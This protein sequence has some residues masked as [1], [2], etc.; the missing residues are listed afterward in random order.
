MG[1]VA[2]AAAREMGPAG[3]RATRLV[4]TL[5]ATVF[6][7]WLGA[8]AI[9]PMLPVFVRRLGGSDVAAGVVMASF[10]A[11]GVLLQYPTGRLADRIGRR[12]VLIG[13]LLLFGAASLGFLAPITPADA[14]LLRALQ[15]AGA[16]AAG[17]AS[18]AMISGSVALERRGRAFAAVYGGEIAGLAIGPL[19]G[20]VIGTRSMWIVFMGSAVLS[21]A[22]SVAALRVTDPRHAVHGGAGEPR[23]RE[24]LVLTRA[25]VGALLAGSSLGLTTGVYEICWT[26]LLVSK[27]AS[28]AEIGISWTLFA[29]PFVLVAK[30]SGWLAD[31]VDRRLLVV[32]GIGSSALLCSSYAFIPSVPVLV[33][34]G[35]VEA[36]SFAAALPSMQSLLTE[37]ADPAHV[38]RL[39]GLFATAQTACTAVAAAAA[40]AAFAT[41]A[42]LPFV[43]VAAL[44]LGILVVTWMVW[45]PVRGHV[46]A[47]RDLR[48][49]APA[50]G[51]DGAL[52]GLVVQRVPAW[53]EAVQRPVIGTEQSA[54]AARSSQPTTSAAL[55]SE[56]TS[57][58]SPRRG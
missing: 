15:G 20:S 30:P 45:R 3:D 35:A 37:G 41:A 44:V 31:H 54:V 13:G 19:V 24:R 18:L 29:V 6:L 23:T 48:S 27:G 34:L 33:V 43:S 53:T 56:G 2:S 57:A 7:Q 32:G 55:A 12:P 39:Q 21:V 4:R 36:M 38:G 1:P 17:V 50:R 58:T 52:D 49:G 47:G 16:G 51:P 10:F 5:T 25:A 11:A 42:W 9:I 8:S 22:A 14:V 26:L 28:G 46:Q 40:G